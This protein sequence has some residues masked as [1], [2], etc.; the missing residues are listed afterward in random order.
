MKPRDSNLVHK[1]IP[2]PKAMTISDAV[3]VDE[4]WKKLETIP[5]WEFGK[6][7]KSKKEVTLQAQRDKRKV[8]FAILMDMSSRKCG[9]GS[10]ITEVWRQCRA[11]GCHCGRQLWSQRGIHWTRLVCVP[12]G[13][14]NYGRHWKMTKLWPTCSWRSICLYSGEIGRCSKIAKHTK[15][16]MSR[17]LEPHSNLSLEPTETENTDKNKDTELV[18]RDLLR[19]LPEW[20]WEFTENLVDERVP[21]HGDAPTSSSQPLRKVVS[22][23]HSIDAHSRRTEIAISAWGVKLQGLLAE[24]ALVQSCPERKVLVFW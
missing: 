10:K 14:K 15:F 16:G 21:A 7:V 4:D 13:C 19:D 24:D 12:D 6:K 1:F 3:A 22:G 17:Y 8:H 9:V 20:L 11:P 18:W 5:A 2:M 23:K